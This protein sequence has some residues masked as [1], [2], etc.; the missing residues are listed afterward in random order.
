MTNAEVALSGTAL[1]LDAALLYRTPAAAA[2]ALVRAGVESPPE[3]QLRLLLI[4]TALPEPVVNR[5]VL[6]RER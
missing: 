2:A 1:R 6:D 5:R 4:L 3:R